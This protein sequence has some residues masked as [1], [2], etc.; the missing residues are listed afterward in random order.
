MFIDSKRKI[1]VKGNYYRLNVKIYDNNRIWLTCS[2][3]NGDYNITINIEEL[4]LDQGKAFLNPDVKRNGLLKELKKKRII[5]EICGIT[6]YNSKEILIASF[7]MGI[8][9]CY[10]NAGMN[11]YV[12]QINGIKKFGG[13][14]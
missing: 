2:N 7:N 13:N 9:R 12:C 5:R 6:Y 14:E 3:K 8:L 11:N 1:K 10:D 4:Y